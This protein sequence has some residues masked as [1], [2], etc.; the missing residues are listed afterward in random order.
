MGVFPS[1]IGGNGGGPG[2]AA[3]AEG[4]AD[5]LGDDQAGLIATP[6]LRPAPLVSW[7]NMGFLAW[8]PDTQRPRNTPPGISDARE[9]VE[10]FQEH[11]V[12]AREQGCG[13][14]ASL[15]SWYRFLIDPEPPAEVVIDEA[16]NL[17]VARG[18]D[19]TILEQRRAFLRHDSLVAIVMLTDENDCSIVDYGQGWLVGRTD[20]TVLP[21]ATSICETDPNNTCCMSCKTDPN[22]VP[23]GCPLPETDPGCSPVSHTQETDHNNLRCWDQKRRFGFDLLHP[24]EKYVQALVQPRIYP[25]TDQN[26]DGKIDQADLVVNPLYAAP[27]GATARDRSLV[28]LAGIVGVPWQDISDE[29][30]WTAPRRLRYLTYD[31]LEAQGRWSWILSE[32]GQFPKD[33]LM[34]E[35]FRDRTTVPGVPQEHPSGLGYT[36][37]NA[38]TTSQTANPINGHEFSDAVPEDLQY[39]CIFPLTET[40]NCQDVPAT[41]GCDCKTE[42]IAA[43]RPLCQ[44]FTQTHAK[45]YP[46]TRILQVLRGFGS[47]TKNAIVAS[48]CPKV[49]ESANPRSDPDYGYNPAVNAIV[50]RLKDALKGRC[51]PRPLDVDQAT[52][53]VPCTV[54]EAVPPDVNGVCPPC[55]GPLLPDRIEPTSPE[56]GPVVRQRLAEDGQCGKG[57]GIECEAFCLCEVQQYEGEALNRCQTQQADPTSPKGYCY[58]DGFDNNGEPSNQELGLLAN[59]P[60]SERQLLRFAS[61]V[62]VKGAIAF[63]ACLGKA[64][65][66]AGAQAM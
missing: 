27:E 35:T 5:F 54:I 13:Y 39:A 3:L 28:F 56:I 34:V 22:F 33:G 44:Q 1:E 23:Q 47:L 16:T 37:A 45:A 9:F 42:D 61:E 25:R 20:G 66:G 26:G 15:E 55:G 30:S 41:T 19:Q 51:L 58:V 7:N 29:E 8:D 65:S 52:G 63:I 57:T 2:P 14:E 53:R 6:G 17:T 11:V 31:E 46:G 4:G 36:L 64:L 48:I 49:V 40:R 10:A 43:N 60:A 21:R 59:C 18:V 32:N 50:D 24:V 12:Q 62:P 38:S